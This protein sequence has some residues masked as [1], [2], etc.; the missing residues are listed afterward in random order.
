MTAGRTNHTKFVGAVQVPAPADRR[1]AGPVVLLGP[2]PVE[3]RGTFCMNERG[4]VNLVFDSTFDIKPGDQ[5]DMT[6]RRN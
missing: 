3:Y 4:G 6:L 1:A 5:F 2:E